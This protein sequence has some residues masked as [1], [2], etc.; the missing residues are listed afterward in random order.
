MVNWELAPGWVLSFPSN[1]LLP[2]GME[3]GGRRGGKD[4]L[5]PTSA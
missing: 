5:F 2:S 3:W 1:L 4:V